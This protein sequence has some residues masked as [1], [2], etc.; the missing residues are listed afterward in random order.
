MLYCVR[1]G[2]LPVMVKSAA[3][4]LRNMNRQQLVAAKEEST[5]FGGYFICNGIERIIRLL[6][7]QVCWCGLASP[8]DTACSHG[9]SY[10]FLNDTR[11]GQPVVVTY[12]V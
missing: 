6:I 2:G 9:I 8:L 7:L 11:P 5:E 12:E 1:L 4:Y 3:C 10:S